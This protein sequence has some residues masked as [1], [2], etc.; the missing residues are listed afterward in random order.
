V[1]TKSGLSTK[2][3]LL[4][5][6]LM[7]AGAAFA[8]PNKGSLE[9]PHPASVAGKQLASGSYS[10]RWEGTGDQVDL[11]I[12]Q[13]KNMVASVPAK[14]VKLDH[15][16]ANNSAVVTSSSDGTYSLSQI[17]FGHKDYALE[18]VTD[19]A[20]SSSGAGASR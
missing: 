7:V 3:F 20:G 2:G 1:N 11:K 13:G 18:I 14:V 12:Y 16:T 5:A 4:T 17:R 8:A 19:A 6:V 9:L 15:P 10:L